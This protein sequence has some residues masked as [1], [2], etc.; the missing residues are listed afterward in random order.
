MRRCELGRLGMPKTSPLLP[1][2]PCDRLEQP[3]MKH[4]QALS[5]AVAAAVL[6]ALSAVS[7][8]LSADRFSLGD[9]VPISGLLVACGFLLALA[10]RRRGA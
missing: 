4:R 1:L 3:G 2:N 7:L 5:V 6:L 10:R 8:A 9:A